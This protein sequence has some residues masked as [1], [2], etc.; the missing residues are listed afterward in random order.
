M[1]K[2][3]CLFCVLILLPVGC[4]AESGPE[5][6]P[7]AFDFD[8]GFELDPN[9]FPEE[10]YRTALGYGELLN[11]TRLSGTF[12]L[13]G[14]GKD[15]FD[16]FLTIS[17]TDKKTA[18]ISMHLF[19]YR[20]YVFIT[21]PLVGE[22]RLLIDLEKTMAVGLKVYD[23]F[24]IP[25]QEATL[26]LPYVNGYGLNDL[27]EIWSA[28]F[29]AGEDV[30]MTEQELLALAE[31][32]RKLPDDSASFSNWLDAVGLRSG[33]SGTV[34]EE[35]E[36]LDMYVSDSFPDGLER[37]ATGTGEEWIS[38]GQTVC[39][40]S[41][42]DGT[43]SFMLLLPPTPDYGLRTEINSQKQ[44]MEDGYSLD[45]TAGIA[46]EKE[47][48]LNLSLTGTG[49]PDR[50][51][52]TKPFSAEILS[53][54]FMTG[55]AGLRICGETD[56][57]SGLSVK[58]QLRDPETEEY[59][60]ALCISGTAVQRYGDE[61]PEYGELLVWQSYFRDAS[62]VLTRLTEQSVSAMMGKILKPFI[63]GI[64]PVL[65]QVPAI[66][67]QVI[68]DQLDEHGVLLFF[69]SGFDPGM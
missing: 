26:L 51:P 48:W 40:S 13:S 24:E 65:V 8:F 10:D 18:E 52:F 27:M 58:L 6:K 69:D 15:C 44:R 2:I 5:G 25:V 23:Y 63:R 3:L 37:R 17:V 33:F 61:N 38:G 36:L 53:S 45:L 19:G 32:L 31:K 4:F 47:N 35:A 16:I 55:D 34:R 12:I 59:R 64:L 42:G 50:F 14:D 68:M 30:T 28:A 62:I 22:E 1:R 43:E 20:N 60:Q 29:P 54:G 41:S 46:S 39:A 57:K 7:L 49:L 56:G 66:T 9:A 67:C 21:S 11:R